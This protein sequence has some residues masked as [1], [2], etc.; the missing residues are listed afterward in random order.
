MTS[1]YE[2]TYSSG[3]VGWFFIV[4]GREYDE[5]MQKFEFEN[6]STKTYIVVRVTRGVEEG[7]VGAVLFVQFEKATGGRE[8][9]KISFRGTECWRVVVEIRSVHFPTNGTH[10]LTRESRDSYSQVPSVV[11]N[12]KG[13]E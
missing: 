8:S 1:Q 11:R 4:R 2:R 13:Q 6:T 5:V 9:T 3:F 12:Q 7:G 10:V